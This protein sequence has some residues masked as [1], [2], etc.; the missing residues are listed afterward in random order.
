MESHFALRRVRDQLWRLPE[1]QRAVLLLV[2]VE[3]LSYKEASAVL[4]IPI[5]TLTSRLAR[6]RHP[7]ARWAA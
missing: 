6:A 7:V 2:A 5:G 1:D 4:D 3:G